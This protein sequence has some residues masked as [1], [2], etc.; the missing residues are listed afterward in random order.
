MIEVT[1]FSTRKGL[2]TEQMCKSSEKVGDCTVDLIILIR[3][4][5]GYM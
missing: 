4:E 3:A 2:E 5:S 1:E